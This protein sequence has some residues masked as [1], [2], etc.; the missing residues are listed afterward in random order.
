VTARTFTFI[1]ADLATT[2]RL[3][4]RFIR[5]IR[6]AILLIG[7]PFQSLRLEILEKGVRSLGTARIGSRSTT[8]VDRLRVPALRMRVHH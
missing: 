3:G 8:P 5:G 1:V 6:C 4:V 2:K 7:F